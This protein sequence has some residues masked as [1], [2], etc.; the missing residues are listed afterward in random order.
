MSFC[1]NQYDYQVKY[2]G[3]SWKDLCIS[4]ATAYP[5]TPHPLIS[6][7]E[8]KLQRLKSSVGDSS[9][10]SSLVCNK[11][12]GMQD[13][14]LDCIDKFLQFPIEQQALAQK[15]NEKCVDDILERS[16]RILDIFSTTKGCLSLSEYWK[17]FKNYSW[18]SEEREELKLD[19]QLRVEKTLFEG[20]GFFLLGRNV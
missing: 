5:S 17:T 9:A 11:L 3:M 18:S 12:N 14:L 13:N 8:N 2:S 20:S 4:A 7:F 10:S 15:C 6:Q 1:N 19:S 16:L